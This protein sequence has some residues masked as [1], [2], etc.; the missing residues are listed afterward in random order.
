[1]SKQ[2][3]YI[4]LTSLHSDYMALSHSI[5]ELIPLKSIIK[6]F[7]DNL[8]MDIDNL[9][10]FLSST[11]YEYNNGTI[12]VTTSPSITTTSKHIYVKYH[13]FRNHIGK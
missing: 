12:F 1:M 11:F 7:I 9:K 8:V 5:R 6:E 2:H 3:R 10:F 13:W 4:F